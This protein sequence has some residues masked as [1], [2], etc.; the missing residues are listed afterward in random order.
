MFYIIT[1]GAAKLPIILE[2]KKW[3][4]YATVWNRARLTA[5]G[6]L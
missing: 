3:I 5:G 4:S 2:I 1:H 6:Y